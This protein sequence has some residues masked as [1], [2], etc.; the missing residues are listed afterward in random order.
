MDPSER[1]SFR[2][3]LSFATEAVRTRVVPSRARAACNHWKRWLTFC[4]KLRIDPYLQENV[5]GFDGIP[6]LQVFAIRYRT[7]VIA[8]SGHAVRSRTV[9]DAVRAVAQEMAAVGSPDP[10]MNVFGKIDFR[11]SSLW[12]SWKHEDPPP[13]RVKPIP[14]KVLC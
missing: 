4:E 10:R 12:Q 13:H 8:P 14:L 3:D 6:F 11:L 7:G 9:E 2:R 1:H 5:D